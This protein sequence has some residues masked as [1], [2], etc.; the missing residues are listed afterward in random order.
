MYPKRNWSYHDYRDSDINTY[1]LAAKN[2]MNKNYNLIRIGKL[3][4]NKLNYLKYDIQESDN[5]F[6]YSDSN[7][8]ND[9]HDIFLLKY[10]KF[11]ICSETGISSVPEIFNVP[12]VYTNWP[13]I[14]EISLWPK[15][16]LYIFKKIYSKSENRYLTF[17]ESFNYNF[18]ESDNYQKMKDNKL[19]LVDNTPEEINDV[20][21]EM[22]MR[23]DDQWTETPEYI[24]L[25]EIFWNLFKGIEK[26]PN[27][28]IG[29]KYLYDNKDLLL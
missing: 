4:K 17:K 19:I 25:Q 28:R 7:I 15:N 3:P 8:Q 14:E 16:A 20:S 10:C 11:F 29:S 9:F 26:S 24:N 6:D 1:L 27:L 13:M 2:L 5:I 21:L 18:S 12:C 23:L 22:Q